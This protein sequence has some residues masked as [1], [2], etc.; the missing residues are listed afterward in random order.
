MTPDLDD[1]DDDFEEESLQETSVSFADTTENVSSIK[2]EIDNNLLPSKKVLEVVKEIDREAIVKNMSREIYRTYLMKRS[3]TDTQPL[4]TSQEPFKL[5]ICDLCKEIC[6][7]NFSVG[8][9]ERKISLRIP[10][11]LQKQPWPESEE[12]LNDS[13][14]QRMNQLILKPKKLLNI[15][16]DGLMGFCRKKKKRDF[17]DTILMQEL[18]DEDPLWTNF[19]DEEKIICEK[20]STM[21][22]DD[23]VSEAVKEIVSTRKNS[24]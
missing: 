11:R 16:S 2:S 19:D 9:K 20:L 6:V 7:E 4:F 17:V 8:E 12:S 13:I 22:T 23:L 10:L 5:F 1:Y 15:Y 14:T 18:I 3:I 21:I 24:S